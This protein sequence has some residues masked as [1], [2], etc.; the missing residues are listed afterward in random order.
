MRSY[1]IESY[2][3][4]KRFFGEKDERFWRAAFADCFV[5][6]LHNNAAVVASCGGTRS[7]EL[8]MADM[9]SLLTL[10][11]GNQKFLLLPCPCGT[12]LVYPAWRHLNFALAFLMRETVDVVEKAYK[13]AQRY[14][15]STLFSTNDQ[16]VTPPN[17]MLQVRLCTLKLYMDSLFGSNRETN[18]AAQILMISNLVGCRLHKMSVIPGDVTLDEMEIER[19]GAYLFCTFITMRHYNGDVSATPDTETNENTDF[20]THVPQKYG[21]L[22]QQGVRERTTEATI[23]DYPTEA[24]IAEFA[25][26]PAFQ[27]HRIEESDGTFR[28]HIPLKQKAV[29]S[30]VLSR[31]TQREITIILFPLE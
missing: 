4:E 16:T 11:D 31:G 3:P 15:V 2:V 12:L 9:A 1:K 20:S 24:A 13:A 5:I 27:N 26:H 19:L 10:F 7:L 25:A 17:E 22:I 8:S 23:F 6:D 21:L 14:P 28:I 29:L 18:L 30:S